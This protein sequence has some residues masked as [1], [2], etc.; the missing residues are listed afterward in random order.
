MDKE[1][2]EIQTNGID[3]LF[4]NIIAENFSRFEKEKDIWVQKSYR[5]LD[6]QDQKKKNTQDIT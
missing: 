6:C 3:N 5:T 1:E 2:E 4:N